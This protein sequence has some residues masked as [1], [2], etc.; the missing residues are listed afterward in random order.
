MIRKSLTILSC[1]L[2]CNATFSQISFEISEL[3]PMPEPVANNAVTSAYS[4][5]SLCVY[6]FCGIDST[7]TPTGIHLKAWRYN[8]VSEVW[9]QLPDVPDDTGNGKIAAGASTVGNKIYLIGGYYVEN[10][11]SEESSD[12]VHVFNPETNSWEEDGAIIPVPIDDHVQAVWNG[13]HIYV[14]TG[15][16]DF[17]NVN[18]VQIY[19]PET[20]EWIEGTSTPNNSDYKVFG[21]SG[22]IVGNTIFYHGGVKSNAGFFPTDEVRKGTINP[23]APEEIE[24]EV[25]GVSELGNTYRAAAVSVPAANAVFWIGGSELGYNFDGI[26]YNNSGGVEPSNRIIGHNYFTPELM[27]EA[28][29]NN[30]SGELIPMDLRGIAKL[31]TQS[32]ETL[33]NFSSIICGGM[34]SNQEVTDKVFLISSDNVVSIDEVSDSKFS[35]SIENKQL[36]FQASELVESIS[37]YDSVGKLLISENLSN[38]SGSIPLNGIS[39]GVYIVNLRFAS[40][41]EISRKVMVD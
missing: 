40:D 12:D 16:S 27:Y 36:Q 32:E 28:S 38:H 39:E 33:G 41:L 31:S 11:F 3:P 1:V 8:T 9:S 26:D 34:L 19:H 6:S 29:V 5:D 30:T 7:K 24:W 21:G 2:I 14:V 20:N 17:Q 37:V 13:S 4:G 10:N 23:D 35:I 15:W 22:E 18:D 25:L